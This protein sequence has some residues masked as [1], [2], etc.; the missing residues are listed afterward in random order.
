MDKK[1]VGILITIFFIISSLSIHIN[2][3][4][5]N[6]EKESSY[7]SITTYDTTDLTL[8]V[9]TIDENHKVLATQT[10][11]NKEIQKL[12]QFQP[13]VVITNPDD[14]AEVTN[15]YIII[16]GYAA[17]DIGM[18][19]WQ[20]TWVWTGGSQS[21]DE[22]IDTTAYYEFSLDIGPLVVG[23]NTITI[24]FFNT[25][26]QTGSD[27]VTVYYVVDDSDP[28][29]VV[30]TYPED[31]AEFD[32]PDLTVTG[33][34]NDHG[35]SGVVKI[36][37][38]HTWDGG[39]DIDE[40]SYSIPLDYMV[41]S[42]PITLHDGENTIVVN[43]MDS[44]GNSLSEPPSVIVYYIRLEGLLIESV[45]QPVQTVYPDDPLYGDSIVGGPC[46]YRCFLDMVAGKNT[47]L[48]GY[49]YNDRNQIKI[50]VHNNYLSDKTFSFVF[51]IYPDD[52]VIWRS[53]PVTV[54]A[55]ERKTFT[56]NAPLPANPFQWNRWGSNPRSKPSKIVLYI[57]PDYTNPPANCRCKNVTMQLNVL[58]TH[59]LRVLFVPFT[60]YNGPNFPA[61]LRGPD[62]TSFDMWRWTELEPWWR[63][64]YPVRE[65]LGIETYRALLGNIRSNLTV[66][67]ITVSDLAS[68]HAL[69]E[70][71][72]LLLW[73]QLFSSAVA[74]EWMKQPAYD[75]IVWL[76]HPEVMRW[77]GDPSPAEGLAYLCPPN[78]IKQAVLVNW[79]DRNNVVPHEIS[80]TY[81]LE[82]C[83]TPP[84]IPSLAVGYWVNK[85][86]DLTVSNNH[87][88]L[89][90]FVHP[91]WNATGKCWIKKPNFMDL[92]GRF[93]V[94][95]DP[96]VLGIVGSIDKQ[97]NVILQPWYE[98]EE[99]YIDLFWD[100]SGDYMIKAYD[101]NSVLI[102]KTGFSV[103]YFLEID[104]L[105]SIPV[106]NA[107]F[108]FRIK[109][110]DDI[111]RIDI[112]SSSTGEVLASRTR[113]VNNPIVK[114]TLPS[115]GEKIK[116]KVYRI[117]W[118]SSDADGDA[119]IYHLYLSNDSG[120]TW[121]PISLTL[122]ENYYDFD[123]TGLSVGE[124]SIS[125]VG[126]D[127]WN[128]VSD[129]VS[130]NVKK[131]KDKDFVFFGED[132]LRFFLARFPFLEKIL[133]Q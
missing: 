13:T 109:F 19:Y 101:K 115:N 42:I 9:K 28:P 29:E 96:R 112:T 75:R 71:N 99:G 41:F 44:A 31:G 52:K 121:Y 6:N 46:L 133:N 14:G 78:N 98:I 127:N 53:D 12:N 123:F 119:I 122:T 84:G 11:S 47:Y 110:D 4:Q 56:Y 25:L 77:P 85:K 76:V 63:A 105:G 131:S 124:Y 79:S 126:S 45:F 100:Q 68:L 128:T 24:T 92:L 3:Q 48:F 21:G 90:W 118:S 83:Y 107:L 16:E 132:F 125:V 39:S 130:F 60:F 113:S 54:L 50:D 22:F 37:W 80:H 129:T 69:N 103:D 114:I 61:D 111:N 64:I 27:D 106:D 17:D 70:T 18:N 73:N 120:L 66:N 65:N 43:A 10:P 57:D 32:E 33:H 36:F 94:N 15:P 26:E 34:A 104:Y 72:L 102:N 89:M 108:S 8:K 5:I 116:P 1:I 62:T 88:D 55:G 2:S 95:D 87:R 35:G 20:W 82:D 51:K 74:L 40:E 38:T 58:Y 49:P 59:D 67:G 93:N 86:F 97:D 81:G 23:A 91:L 7:G 30:I 117:K